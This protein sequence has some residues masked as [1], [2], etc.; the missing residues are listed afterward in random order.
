MKRLNPRMNMELSLKDANY[1]NELIERDQAKPMREYKYA[2]GDGSMA[3]CPCCERVINRTQ[4]FCG[5]CGQRVDMENY[6]L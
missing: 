6:E 2:S 1:I 5:W 3:L 4:Y